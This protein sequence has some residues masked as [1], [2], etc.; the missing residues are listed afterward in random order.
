V[1][2]AFVGRATKSRAAPDAEDNLRTTR[3][4]PALLRG[5]LR[6]SAV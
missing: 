1:L 3:S 6:G 5:P 4:Q 2:H